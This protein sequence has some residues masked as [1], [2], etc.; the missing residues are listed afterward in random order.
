MAAARG[1]EEKGLAIARGGARPAASRAEGSNRDPMRGGANPARR[2]GAGRAACE[3]SLRSCISRG[4][5]LY[6]RGVRDF[7]PSRAA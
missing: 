1:G 3:A 4:A 7:G 2:A 6:W 5:Q